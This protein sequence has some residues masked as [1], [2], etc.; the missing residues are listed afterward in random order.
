MAVEDL[1]N[2]R[3]GAAVT[4]SDSTVVSFRG[5]YV[6]VGGDVSI[7]D[8]EGTTLVFKNVPSGGEVRMGCVRVNAATT[9]TNIIGYK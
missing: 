6:G 2:P 3:G 9:A 5:L 7:V 1:M 8:K 4:P